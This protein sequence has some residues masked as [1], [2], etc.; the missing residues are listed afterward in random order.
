[1][2]GPSLPATTNE[3]PEPLA[4]SPRR[5][6]SGPPPPGAHVL[7]VGRGRAGGVGVVPGWRLGG[8]R[9]G[10]LQP[11]SAASRPPAPR[12]ACGMNVGKHRLPS[13]SPHCDDRRPG[14][15]RP[16]GY[17]CL[18]ISTTCR[19][20]SSMMF[21]LVRESAEPVGVA[22]VGATRL[23][24]AEPC[25]RRR[26]TRATSPERVPTRTSSSRDLRICDRGASAAANARVVLPAGARV[27]SCSHQSK[28]GRASRESRPA[29][30]RG[31]TGYRQ[32][33]RDAGLEGRA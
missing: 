29:E 8:A 4:G 10:R 16:P 2:S 20:S 3:A 15:G 31:D 14:A 7:E 28:C 6:T 13:T 12:C 27:N 19:S 33:Q 23:G 5:R 17:S 32:V 22:A 9:R 11:L 18:G 30:R 21:G 26:P 1:M 25:S 24:G